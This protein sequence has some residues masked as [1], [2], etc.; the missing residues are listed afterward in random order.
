MSDKV[1]L[2]KTGASQTDNLLTLVGVVM[3]AG[4]VLVYK[5]S[6]MNVNK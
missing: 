3:L 2:P 5:R 6:R 1:S 4:S